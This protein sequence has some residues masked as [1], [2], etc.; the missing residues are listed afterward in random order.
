MEQNEFS[1]FRNERHFLFFPLVFL[2]FIGCKFCVFTR[3]RAC[4][5]VCV[6]VLFL[7]VTFYINSKELLEVWAAS[8]I[9]GCTVTS[10]GLTQPLK[11]PRHVISKFASC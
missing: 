1:D 5:C 4:V 2:N 9:A 7:V 8:F 3:A 10:C 11:N 6:C